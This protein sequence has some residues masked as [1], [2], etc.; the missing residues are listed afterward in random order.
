V[1]EQDIIAQNDK[2]LH[3]LETKLTQEKVEL[4]R[5]WAREKEVGLLWSCVIC[6]SNLIDCAW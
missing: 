4:Q 5:T 3:E 1:R 6:S 2:Q